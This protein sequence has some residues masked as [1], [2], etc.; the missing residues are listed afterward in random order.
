MDRCPLHPKGGCGF[1]YVGTYARKPSGTRVP[2]WHCP[3][4]KQTF[5]LLADCLAARFPDTLRDIEQV[6]DEVELLGSVEAAA[7]T[8]RGPD[9]LL[10]GAIRWVRRRLNAVRATLIPLIGLMPKRFSTCQPTLGSFR[11][12]LGVELVLPA[13]RQIVTDQLQ[14]FPPPVGFSTRPKAVR[15]SKR[16]AP[17]STGPDPPRKN[18]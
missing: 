8:M 6:V 11:E 4:G 5:S 15:W 16:R 13:L 17:H 12:T 2:R 1:R 7:H 18:R 14:A 10:P 9:V 3:K